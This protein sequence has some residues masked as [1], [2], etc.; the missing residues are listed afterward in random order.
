MEEVRSLGQTLGC[1]AHLFRERADTRMASCGVTPLQAHVILFL[2]C[3]GGSLSQLELGR[4]LR[5][6]PS[7]VNGIVDRM[8]ERGLV[9]RSADASDARRRRVALTQGGMMQLERCRQE[10]LDTERLVEKS[11]SPGE[12]AQLHSL[13]GR[14]IQI[15]EEDREKC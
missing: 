2:N 8:V 11:L 12:L 9:E 5:V 7:T 4:H 15:L 6:K 14:V 3:C 13:L 1:A 10:L